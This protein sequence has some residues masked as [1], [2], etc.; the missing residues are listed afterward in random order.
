MSSFSDA[1]QKSLT[2]KY[3]LEGVDVNQV[4]TVISAKRKVSAE[5]YKDNNEEIFNSLFS[6]EFQNKAQNEIVYICKYAPN[7][8]LRLKK[9]DILRIAKFESVKKI[10]YVDESVTFSPIDVN[11]STQS[12]E[13]ATTS[14]YDTSYFNVTGLTSGRD[15]WGLNGNGM[16]LGIIEARDNAYPSMFPNNSINIVYGPTSS[17]YTDTTTH[18]AMVASILVGKFDDYK[19]AVPNATLYS[20]GVTYLR[21]LK[22]AMEALLSNDITAI[23]GSLTQEG[24]PNPNTYGDISKYY[25]YVSLNNDVTVILASG[26]DGAVGVMHTNMAYNAIVVGRCDNDGLIDDSSSYSSS[27]NTAFKPDMVAPGTYIQTPFATLSGTS[28][29][30]PMVTGAVVQLTMLSPTLLYNPTLIKALL[31]GNSKITSSMNSSDVISTIGNSTPALSRRYGAG[32]LNVTNAYTS[33]VDNGY[34]KTATM[35]NY[36]IGASHG[37]TIYRAVNKTLRVC[38]T[39]D[40]VIEN[41]DDSFSESDL[42]NFSLSVVTPSGDTYTSSGTFDNKQMVSFVATESGHYTFN[43]NRIGQSNSNHVVKYSISYSL[44]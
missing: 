14:A 21:D 29:S 28:F 40:K 2:Y 26:N 39:W 35:S 3:S 11:I 23:N 10:Y 17:A 42:D 22:P 32:L 16:K 41:S 8:D 37:K 4:Q 13:I 6:S 30:A 20:A 5:M 31:V 24:A 36:S 18:A 7:M 12:C 19:G 44:K 27:N 34:Y 1:N 43:V 25:D 9:S 33:F 15:V 38:L